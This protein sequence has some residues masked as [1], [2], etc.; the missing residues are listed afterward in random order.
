MLQYLGRRNE[1]FQGTPCPW[2]LGTLAIQSKL[3]F[4]E[5]EMLLLLDS[6]PWRDNPRK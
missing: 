5:L 3:L 4:E 2:A 1:A 6:L